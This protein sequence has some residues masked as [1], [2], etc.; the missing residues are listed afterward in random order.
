MRQLM[1]ALGDPQ[2]SYPAVHVTGTNGKTSTARMVEALL[3]AHGLRVGMT[4]SPHLVSPLERLAVGGASITEERMAGLLGLV[5]STLRADRAGY[6][7]AITAAGLVWFAECQVD[8][9][10]VE[11][12]IGGRYDA[13]NVVD[14]KVAVITNVALDHVEILGPS[15][16]DIAWDKAGIVKPGSTLVLA[17]S[18][19]ELASIFEATPACPLWRLGRDFDCEKNVVAPLG[20]DVTLRTPGARYEQ[21]ALQLHGAYQ[22]VN[23]ACALA[24][25]EALVGRSLGDEEVRNAL[26]SVTSPGRM[27]VLGTAPW[28][29]LDGAKNPAGAAAAARAIAEEFTGAR[30]RILVVGMLS[31]RD[32]TEML[33]ALSADSARLVVATAPSDPRAFPAGEV[34]EAARNLGLRTVEASSVG[35][36]LGIALAEAA[37]DDLVLVSGSLYVVGEARQHLVSRSA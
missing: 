12:G 22:G 36:A 11:V 19:P 35:E 28:L 16:A 29:I 10:V 20:R 18:D 24:G 3:R 31:G 6:F 1:A 5:G 15:R 33:V 27:E 21:V 8:A 23:A 2:L 25:A 34:G 7:E 13:T 14:S 32:P 9:A 26:A 30:S 17:E 37:A 4:T